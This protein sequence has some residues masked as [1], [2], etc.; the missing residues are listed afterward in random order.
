MWRQRRSLPAAATTAPISKYGDLRA[1]A[2]SDPSGYVPVKPP[3][4]FCLPAT[5]G[6]CPVNTVD[7][8]H[9]QPLINDRAVTQAFAAPH[10]QNVEPFALSS[11]AHFDNLP[12]VASGPNYLQSPARY[13]SDHQ[14]QQHPDTA[15]KSHRRILG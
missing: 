4:P 1:G 2:Y 5:V 15:A 11:A 13:R 9:W 8:Y 12:E 6:P 10:W 7:P 14:H 3:M